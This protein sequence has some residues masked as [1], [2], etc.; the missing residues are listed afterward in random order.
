MIRSPIPIQIIQ[1]DDIIGENMDIFGEKV[2]ILSFI[3]QVTL[4]INERQRKIPT[5]KLSKSGG[6]RDI[7]PIASSMRN[8]LHPNAHGA[9][10]VIIAMRI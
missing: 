10:H 3:N 6:A 7:L 4:A 9:N 5:H 2:Y 8:M 1:N